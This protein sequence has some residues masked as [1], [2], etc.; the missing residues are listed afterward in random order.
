MDSKVMQ[1][2]VDANYELREY[3]GYSGRGMYGNTTDGIVG[4]DYELFKAI[5][6]VMLHGS[7]EDKQLL[8]RELC[9]GGWRTDSMGYDTIY[10]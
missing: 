3:E 1:V 7:A 5:G 4:T 8:G 10:Y 6:E 2:L 9:D